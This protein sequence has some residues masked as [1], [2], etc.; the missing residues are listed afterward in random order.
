LAAPSFETMDAGLVLGDGGVTFDAT[1]IVSAPL[2]YEAI[3]F[4]P[5]AAPGA[6]PPG[7]TSPAP[8]TARYTL[9]AAAL[10]VQRTSGAAARV[11]APRVGQ[12]RFRSDAAPPAAT[13]DPISWRIVRD[14]DDGV[15]AGDPSV[16]T[17]S[18]Y[19]DAPAA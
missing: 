17:W 1:T 7:P 4:N 18:E 13:L 8:T 16:S 12:P 6:T 14:D 19:R 15:A 5:P 9:P 11:P 2:T 10:A 3:T